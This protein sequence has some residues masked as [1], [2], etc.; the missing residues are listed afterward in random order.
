MAHPKYYRLAI[1]LAFCIGMRWDSASGQ[2]ETSDP[3]KQVKSLSDPAQTAEFFLPEDKQKYL[4]DIEHLAL[5]MTQDVVPV[6]RTVLQQG[7][8]EN[9]LAFLAPEFRGYVFSGKGNAAQK[10]PVKLQTWQEEQPLKPVDGPDFA[11][12]LLSYGRAFSKVE[13][14]GIH[15]TSLTP[16][17]DGDL[18]GSW[19]THWE[20]DLK[21]ALANGRVP[22]TGLKDGSI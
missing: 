6:F 9:L 5:V 2:V 3:P 7:R 8:T 10:G 15:F 18:E 16:E 20:I 17:K 22:N 19:T 11:E 4:W 14:V 1:V 13:K 12:A 21:G